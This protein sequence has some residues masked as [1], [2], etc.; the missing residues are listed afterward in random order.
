M[1]PHILFFQ[2]VQGMDNLGGG[3]PG[4]NPDLS[5]LDKRLVK[6]AFYCLDNIILSS[7]SL[8][9]GG[10]LSEQT[11]NVVAIINGENLNPNG[12]GTDV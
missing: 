11:A 3:G 7:N 10:S 4:P 9:S 2:N 8:S 1:N 6:E 12:A 5:P